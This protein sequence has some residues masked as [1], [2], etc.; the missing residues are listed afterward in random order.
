MVWNKIAGFFIG[1]WNF[2]ASAAKTA[3]GL[4]QSYIVAPIVAVWQ[5]LVS[6]WSTVYGWLVA[7]WHL[8]EA[9]AKVAWNAIKVAII[10]PL[11]ATWNQ[12]VSIW[13][14]ISG[15]LGTVWHGIASAASAVWNSIKTAIINPL[16]SAWH[17]VTG[18]VGKIGSAIGSGLQSAWNA[19]SNIGSKF[20]SI[21]SDIISGIISGI[22]NA[23]G[24]LFSALG[25]IANDALKSAKSFLGIG[26]P[27]KEFAEQV[28]QWIPHGIAQGITKYS[29]VAHAAVK[30]LTGQLT[31][32]SI[33]IGTAA[34][35]AGGTSA[36]VGGG[37][38]GA[39]AQVTTIIQVDGEELFRS[40][41]P[42]ALRFDRRNSQAGLVY[43]RG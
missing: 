34:L 27:S 31:S 36:A 19:V 38:A 25:K 8:I 42:H 15:W 10:N 43:V 37:S 2:I 23:A 16:T 1:I 39:T 22:E 7:L 21:G 4:V 3:W 6:A 20:L 9:G 33:G 32:Q 28:G 40:M 12:I 11:V 26:S 24:S 14:T 17:S 13:H 41:Q 35:G 18:I 30:N 29:G 5:W